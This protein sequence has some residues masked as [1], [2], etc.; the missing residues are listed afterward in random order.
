MVGRR[1]VMISFG[2]IKVTI[3][4]VIL[5]AFLAGFIVVSLAQAQGDSGKFCCDC[6]LTWLTE[7]PESGIEDY[8]RLYDIYCDKNGDLK[9]STATATSSAGTQGVKTVP[10]PFPRDDVLTP[11]DSKL[12]RF[13][14]LDV[15]EP[16]EYNKGHIRGSRSLYWKNTQ[17]GDKVNPALVE[18]ALREIGVNNSDSLLIYGG[19]DDKASYVLWALGYIGHRNLSKLD[20]GIDE[21][22]KAGVSLEKSVTKE[23]S[24]NYTVSLVQRF[25][26]NE[27]Q[28]G[29]FVGRGDVQILDARDFPAFGQARLTNASIPMTASKF[30]LEGGKIKDALTLE[31]LFGRRS[32]DKSKIQLVYGTPEAYSLFYA[33]F[34][35]GYNATVLEGS[36]WKDTKWVISTIR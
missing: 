1:V 36:W 15:R 20:G 31:D 26:V 8:N 21:A 30:Y 3:A 25:S 23:N 19:A 34:L 4:Q 17:S 28:L 9:T 27:S 11:P 2:T 5:A 18:G 14:V 16:G 22:V 29:S 7:H 33:L 35:M 6:V 24:S 32:L 13:V 10:E 12:E